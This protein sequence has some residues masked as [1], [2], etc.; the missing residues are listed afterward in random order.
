[1]YY[2]QEQKDNMQG[3][4]SSVFL[5][6]LPFPQETNCHLKPNRQY[7]SQINFQLEMQQWGED[8]KDNFNLSDFTWTPLPLILGQ[9]MLSP[10]THLTRCLLYIPWDKRGS[11]YFRHL[12]CWSFSFQYSILKRQDSQVGRHR[13]DV[14]NLLD[15]VCQKFRK[16]LI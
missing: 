8:T 16:S 1:M 15:L 5:L 11:H 2:K 4:F 6:S 3:K 14:V 9:K 10:F 7:R 12:N 13:S